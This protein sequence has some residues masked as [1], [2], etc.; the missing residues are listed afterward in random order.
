MISVLV[1]SIHADKL[2]LMAQSLKDTIGVPYE[3]LS[4]DNRENSRGICEVYNTLAAQ[5][6]FDFLCFVHEDVE[7]VTPQWGE[8]LIH[9]A[10]RADTGCIGLAGGQYVGRKFVSWGDTPGYDYWNIQ[11]KN[12]EQ[13]DH[14]QHNPHHEEYTPSISLDGVFLFVR[15]EIWQRTQF[16]EELKGF[17]LYDADFSVRVA[18]KYQNY[19][20]Q[21]LSLRHWS[22]GNAHSI[23]YY[24]NLLQFQAAHH[25]HLPLACG[26]A[27]TTS[28]LWK[29]QYEAQHAK[30]LFE[31]ISQFYGVKYSLRKAL[32]GLSIVQS[33]FFFRY[34]ST[35]VIRKITGQ[36]GCR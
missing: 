13:F 30:M 2:Q 23:A 21:W 29:I 35:Y 8:R 14:L 7:F 6:Q 36:G 5:A 19:V 1:C 15:K 4:H 12:G 28:R 33:V 26:N 9:M 20:C 17:H 27:T 3:L 22:A 25:K 10:S 16:A 24:N 31:R 18:R 32:A 34:M 11:Q